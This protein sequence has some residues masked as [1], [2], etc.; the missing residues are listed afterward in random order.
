MEIRR[1]GPMVVV[2]QE[3]RHEKKKHQDMAHGDFGHAGNLS[4]IPRSMLSPATR[5]ADRQS[6]VNCQSYLII[7]AGTA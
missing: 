7:A 4:S 3:R 6:E 5:I 2:S 1:H